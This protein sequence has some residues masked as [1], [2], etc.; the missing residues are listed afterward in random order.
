MKDLAIGLTMGL[1]SL[2]PAIGIGMLV[3]AGLQAIGRNPEASSKIQ[4][5]MVLG[6]AFAEAVAIY[7]L[8]VALIIKF[9]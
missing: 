5:N 6:I 1:G 7:A 3:S 9:V 4:T 8:V 2:G